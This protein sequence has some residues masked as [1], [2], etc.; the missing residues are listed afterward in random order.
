MSN[1]IKE[2]MRASARLAILRFLSEDS[3]YR[4]NTSLLQDALT[5]IG[6]DMTRAQV[7]TECAWLEERDLVA[8]EAVGAVKVIRLKERGADVASG[9]VLVEG[10][11]RP[12]PGS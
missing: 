4:L 11:K 9:Q 5:A 2:I 6:L 12:G 8:I 10:V 3:D 1:G 7:E